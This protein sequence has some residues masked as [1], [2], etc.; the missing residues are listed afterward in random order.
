[1]ESQ[2]SVQADADK[3]QTFETRKLK[4]KTRY[5][6]VGFDMPQVLLSVPKILT[7]F[8][9]EILSRPAIAGRAKTLSVP[10]VGE[11]VGR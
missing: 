2:R 4:Q 10:P 1:M 5:R 7:L 9:P 6:W 11:P 8:I 3:S